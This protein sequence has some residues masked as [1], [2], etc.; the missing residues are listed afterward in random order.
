MKTARFILIALLLLLG[1]NLEA[2]QRRFTR[3]CP[4]KTY[5]VTWQITHE[6]KN[7]CYVINTGSEKQYFTVT[8]KFLTLS[9]RLV[10]PDNSTDLTFKSENGSYVISGTL[11]GK[12]VQ[13]TVKSKGY[14]WY[15]NL[16]FNGRQFSSTQEGS[17]KKFECFRPYE[18]TFYVMEATDLGN[19]SIE[20]FNA[21][22]VKVNLTGA[23]AGM[24]SCNYYYDSK[25]SDFVVYTSVEGPPGTKETRL[26]SEK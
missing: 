12:K 19:E 4:K 22:H 23:F 11:K 10:N 26:V 8:D 13:K 9:W 20:G 24:W 5:N 17:R 16:E 25:S 7:T 14:P 15:Q 2:Q 21:K 18:T 1:T 3:Y 6:G